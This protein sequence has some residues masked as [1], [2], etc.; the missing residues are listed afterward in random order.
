MLKSFEIT[1]FRLFQHLQV[2]KLSRVNL[3]VGK[4][5]SGKSSFLEA[6]ELYVSNASASIIL[7]QLESRQEDWFNELSP[8]SQSF[9]DSPLRQ[10]FF[11]R[12]LLGL[13]EKGI[14][15]GEIHSAELYISAAAFQVTSNDEALKRTRI[16]NFDIQNYEDLSDYRFSLIAE[17]RGK[18]RIIFSFDVASSFRDLQKRYSTGFY[19]RERTELRHRW[20]TVPTQNISNIK[21]SALW[22]LT[23]LDPDLKT[24]VIEALRL[25]DTRVTGIG[26]VDNMSKGRE[27]GREVRDRILLVV[28]AGIN[29]RI[30]LKSMG[31]GMMRLF[32]IILALVNA[33]NGILLI[34]EFEN[35]L[36][37]SVQPK[38]WDVVFQVAEKLNV[39]VFATTHSRDCIA[40][41]E[42][43]WN[44]YPELGAFFRLDHRNGKIKATE[45]T[46]EILSDSLETDVEVR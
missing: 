1:N 5:N 37:W 2:K 46:A 18:T 27:K 41:F 4:N 13:G 45:Y 6:L 20:Q 32:Q 38:V 15:L 7:G 25:I 16:H 21:L 17:E 11:G 9:V 12:K 36:H 44:N 8:H 34:D 28:M 43:A 10:L 39:Q 23:L 40:G 30:P 3:I 31:D 24:E 42:Q 26:F 14:S 19:E 33:K 22:D 29:E 35:G